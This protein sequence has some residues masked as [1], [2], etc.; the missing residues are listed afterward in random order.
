MFMETKTVFAAWVA[1][2]GKVNIIFDINQT[3]PNVFDFNQIKDLIGYNVEHS[4]WYMAAL[5]YADVTFEGNNV[6]AIEPGKLRIE[7]LLSVL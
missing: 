3:T 2:E 4:G 6:I 7:L 5:Q 1:E